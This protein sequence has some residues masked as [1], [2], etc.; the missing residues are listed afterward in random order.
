MTSTGDSVSDPTDDVR[1]AIARI[2]GM[3][4]ATIPQ[5]AARLDEHDRAL[6]TVAATQV[7]HGE[8]LA[9][10]EAVA[11]AAHRTPPWVAVV[12]AVAG[13]GALVLAVVIFVLEKGGTS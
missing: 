12:S 9:A 6:S 13:L 3:L 10:V 7:T 5:H 2:E 4:Q 1:V 11:E 8:R